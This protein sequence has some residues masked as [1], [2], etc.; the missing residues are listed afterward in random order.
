MPIIS[1]RSAEARSLKGLHLYHFSMSNCSQ[2]ARLCLEEKRLQWISHPVNITDNQHL[3]RSS[4]PLIQKG[5]C[6]AGA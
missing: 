2:K 5:S 4:W 1:S 3:T 6:G